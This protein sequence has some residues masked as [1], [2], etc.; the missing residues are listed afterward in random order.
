V[1]ATIEA[2][3][4]EK[5]GLAVGAVGR[6]FVAGVVRRHMREV[7]LVDDREYLGRLL[8]SR[9]FWESL[10][11][12]IVIPETWFFRNRESFRYFSH[13][14]QYDWLPSGE[15]VMSVL[16]MPCAT[17]EEPYSIAMTLLEAG[18]APDRFRIDAMDISE[19]S[20]RRGREGVYGP[21][22]FRGSDLGY[23]DRYFDPVEGGF[24]IRPPIVKTVRFFKGNILDGKFQFGLGGYNAIFCRNLLIYLTPSAKELTVGV[25]ARLLKKTGVVFV[26]H[27]EHASFGAAGLEKV[28]QSGVFA[29]RKTRES[30]KTLGNGKVSGT[31]ALMTPRSGNSAG[32]MARAV[33]PPAPP[34][35]F[36]ALVTPVTSAQAMAPV[37]PGGVASPEASGAPAGEEAGREEDGGSAAEIASLFGTAEELAN[38]GLMSEALEIC[39]KLLRKDAFHVGGHFLMGVVFLALN[40]NPAAARS[41]NKAAYLDRNH[42][43]ALEHLAFIAEHDGDPSGAAQ[44][45]SRAERIRAREKGF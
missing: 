36:V 41:F 15:E 5:I 14:A 34:A 3:L 28:R 30:S 27:I 24:R 38:R 25:L 33:L 10:V 29:F 26:G 8:E 43:E 21:E 13:F 11:E 12:A 22:S 42:V 20:L 45:R 6:E 18:L 31:G 32:S 17:G 40:D 16:S 4:E 9:P 7:G 1:I 2:I 44:F 39:G 35:S 37:A 23:R 19:P